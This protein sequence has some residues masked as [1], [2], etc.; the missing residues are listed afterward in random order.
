MFKKPTAAEVFTGELAQVGEW[1]VACVEPH[2]AWPTAVQKILYRGHTIFVLPQCDDFYPALAVKRGPGLASYE[3]AQVLILNL[4]SAMSWVDDHGAL[5]DQ[6]T[7]GSR[8]QP[9]AGFA[10]SGIPLIVSQ[11]FDYHYLPDV[12]DQKSRWAL[13]FYREGL[14]IHLVAYA[15]L[16]FY[17]I[18]NILHDGGARQKTWINANL[19][20]ATA[21]YRLGG[22]KERLQELQASGTNI[23][24]YLYELG[25]C[26]VAHAGQGPTVDPEKP[27]DLKRL[28][29]DLPLIRAL[30][31]HAIEAEFKIKSAATIYKEHLYEL[32]G[33]RDILGS[34]LC[35]R[36]KDGSEVKVDEIPALPPLH[37][38]LH[39]KEDYPPL[40]DLKPSVTLVETGIVYLDCSSSDGRTRMLLGLDVANER[41]Q[42]NIF[43][44]TR[45]WSMM[46][47]RRRFGAR[48]P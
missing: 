16:S 18:I 24:D 29:Q 15:F 37:I 47:Q 20:G 11:H 3:Q 2:M 34:A 48:Q 40:A 32:A 14:S 46:A 28:T 5:V 30:A 43:D 41:L 45:C 4:L 38:A 21:K 36:L 1:V 17:K 13:A 44:G 9:M 33:F 35:Q 19:A 7:G 27:A 25:R 23:G 8:A 42:C 39:G 31:A 22:S 10:R 26:A 12:A 6:W